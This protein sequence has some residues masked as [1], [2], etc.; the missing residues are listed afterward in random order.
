MPGQNP[1]PDLE[2]LASVDPEEGTVLVDRL[3]VVA[4][5]LNAEFR[6]LSRADA[7]R[8]VFTAAKEVLSSASVV[9]FVPTF[10][11]RRARHLLHNGRGPAT[12]RAPKEPSP[13]PSDR[14]V[15]PPPT[16]FAAVPP[17]PDAFYTNEAKRLLERARH[18]RAGTFAAVRG[19]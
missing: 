6:A 7:E 11:E 19:R 4:E 18:L 16:Q 9:Q 15:P 10:A 3:R 8:L 12:E 1:I 14:V 5:S 2:M 17:W 13:A